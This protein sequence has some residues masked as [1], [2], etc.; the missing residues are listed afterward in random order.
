MESYQAYY[1]RLQGISPLGRAYKRYFVSPIV[2]YQAT[3]FGAKIAEI[4]SGIGSGI[5]GAYPKQVTGFD[6]N[7][8]AVDYCKIKSLT[9]YQI[10]EN[11]NYPAQPGEFDVCVLDNVLEHISE[12]SFILQECLRITHEK[13]GLIIAVPGTK[14]YLLDTDHKKFYGTQELQN[15]HPNWKLIS[16][17]SVPFLVQSNFLSKYISQYCLVAVYQKR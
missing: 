8:L 2:Y 5:L 9:V 1:A 11:R 15:L 16:L 10:Y 17:F 13:A 7:P 4:G 6:I 3:Q 14:G 12:P